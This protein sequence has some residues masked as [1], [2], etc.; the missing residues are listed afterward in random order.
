MPL[1]ARAA[2]SGAANLNT[3]AAGNPAPRN[4][5]QRHAA[6]SLF[7]SD[8]RCSGS[9]AVLRAFSSFEYLGLI[10]ALI[11]IPRY[12]CAIETGSGASLLQTKFCDDVLLTRY[13]SL[14][15]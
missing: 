1:P 3:E 10:K 12:D 4:A 14:E 11:I 7:P 9:S 2:P 15:I 13:L 6:H 5:T 8:T